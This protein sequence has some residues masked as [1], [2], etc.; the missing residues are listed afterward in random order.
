MI[1]ALVQQTFYEPHLASFYKDEYKVSEY[2]VGLLFMVSGGGSFIGTVLNP[3]IIRY[4]SVRVSLIFGGILLGFST[5]MIAPVWYIGSLSASVI[6]LAISSMAVPMVWSS[7]TT[8]M[9]AIL[10]KDNPEKLKSINDKITSLYM[11]STCF[12]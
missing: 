9:T 4:C 12:S 10:L 1:L 6:S 5:M 2:Y 3:V 8:A 11:F 7:A